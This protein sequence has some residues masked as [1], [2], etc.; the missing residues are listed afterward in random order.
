MSRII[1]MKKN[2]NLLEL[3]IEYPEQ[4]NEIMLEIRSSRNRNISRFSDVSPNKPDKLTDTVRQQYES[5][6]YFPV[7]DVGIKPLLTAKVLF[8]AENNYTESEFSFNGSLW[9][10]FSRTGPMV[11]IPS[12]KLLEWENIL[13][14]KNKNIKLKDFYLCLRI[15]VPLYLTRR[16]TAEI[17]LLSTSWEGEVAAYYKAGQDYR[18]IG[19][20]CI[21]EESEQQKTKVYETSDFAHER[22]NFAVKESIRYI[23][24]SKIESVNSPLNGGFYLFYDLDARTYRL[25]GWL[26]GWGPVIRA[27]LEASD[28][29]QITEIYSKNILIKTAYKAGLTSLIGI[30]H[31]P[32]DEIDGL[33]TARWDPNP[34]M[35]AGNR[36]RVNSAADSGYLCGFAWCD[37]YKKTGDKRFLDAALLFAKTTKRLMEKDPVPPQDY[38][39]EEGEWSKHTLDESG[40]GVKAFDELYHLTGDE[41]YRELGIRYMENHLRKFQRSD[42][43]WERA[44]YRAVDYA[45]KCIYMTRGLGWAM[46][47]L[48]CTYNLSNDPRYL[49]LACDMASCLIKAQNPDGS[50]N[51]QFNKTPE[52]AG[53]DDK[54]TP[55]WSMLLYRL[56]KYT[57]D[58]SHLDAAQ[59]ALT[60][61]MENQI[62]K[63][64]PEAI[65]GIAGANPQSAVVYRPW[66]NISCL[67]SS[68]FFVLA[69]L[70]EI[71]MNEKQ[72]PM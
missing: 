15:P 4:T 8:S 6:I 30:V 12:Y 33:S 67:Y 38:W 54:G 59:K 11:E 68:A 22:L 10:D 24:N 5:E 36:L 49:N 66:F 1:H 58:K 39:P 57:K 56:Y 69:I 31:K 18:Y 20:A 47:G 63:G 28:L 40:F 60:W 41:S 9:P 16:I 71:K 2:K 26:W 32:G 50:W 27:L 43:L 29:P 35:P 7:V 72:M 14:L 62:E 70:E 52:Q 13:F 48:L 55:L 23:L 3:T 17:S 51:Y 64:D 61:C 25:P 19:T 53:F 46:E 21:K 37:L 34:S 44:Y 42:G 65:G 45:D